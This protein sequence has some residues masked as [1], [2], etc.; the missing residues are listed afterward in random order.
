MKCKFPSIRLCNENFG[1]RFA[2]LVENSRH[3]HIVKIFCEISAHLFMYVHH[4]FMTLTQNN[5]CFNCIHFRPQY[6][7]IKPISIEELPMPKGIPSLLQPRGVYRCHFC[8]KTYKQHAAL[9]RHYQTKHDYH[10]WKVSVIFFL[11]CCREIFQTCYVLFAWKWKNI[12][13]SIGFFKSTVWKMTLKHYHDFLRKV[14][15]FPSN[16]SKIVKNDTFTK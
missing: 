16:W 13:E 3:F 12:R 10:I 1:P 11:F 8:E 5:F 4:W 9:R 14:L 6:V 2:R 7:M 15:F